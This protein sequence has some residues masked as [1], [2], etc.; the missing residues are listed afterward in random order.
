MEKL[1]NILE[2]LS[3]KF[4]WIDDVVGNVI[5]TSEYGPIV[6]GFVSG[7]LLAWLLY[8][9]LIMPL[10]QKRLE[11]ELK[12]HKDQFISL[13]SHYLLNPITI[14]QTAVSRLQEPDKLEEPERQKLYDAILR[15]E[16][17]LWIT[18]EQIMVVNEI[19]RNELRLNV[20]VYNISDVVSSAITVVDPFARHRG[21]KIILQDSTREIQEARFDVRRM[22]QAVIAILDNAIKF[23]PEGCTITISL[24]LEG[25]VFTIEVTDPG[26]GMPAGTLKNVGQ[27][28]FRGNEI[29][30][31][32]YEGF[33]LGLY[34]AKAIIAFHQGMIVFESKPTLG[35]KVKIEFPSL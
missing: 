6:A 14:I 16:Q 11:K 13:A 8:S 24:G 1:N 23:S 35:T 21:I 12:K 26:V 10:Q 3:V 5:I 9:A 20:D 31:F 34:I 17:R 4:L 27:K 28:F 2:W 33:G 7:I 30:N 25:G 15:G 32:D 19:D 18:T 22:K 29:Y